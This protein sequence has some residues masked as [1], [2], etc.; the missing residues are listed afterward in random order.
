MAGGMGETQEYMKRI[1][2][3]ET[4]KLTKAIGHTPK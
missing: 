1:T 2:H 3:S 4:F